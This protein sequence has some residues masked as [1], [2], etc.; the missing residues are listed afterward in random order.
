M[1]EE[2]KIWHLIPARIGAGQ[3]AERWPFFL[4]SWISLG[5][6]ATLCY[7]PKL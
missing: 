4:G 7:L 5:H 3:L 2:L 1:S 6:P